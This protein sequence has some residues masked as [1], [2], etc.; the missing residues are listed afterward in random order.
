MR[1]VEFIIESTIN[2]TRAHIRD[3]LFE[4]VNDYLTTTLAK[5]N[6]K[7]PQDLFKAG[8][9]NTL[10][11]NHLALILTG[12]KIIA[13]P[14]YRAGLTKRDVGINPNDA[15][16]LFNLLNQVDKQGKDSTS[17]LNVFKSLCKMAPA[18]LKQQREALD[19]FKTG[20]DAERKHAAQDLQ[21]FVLKVAQVFNKVHV[22]AQSTRGVDIPALGAPGI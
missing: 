22:S 19:I 8:D 2:Q 7:K 13:N 20:D 3:N 14:D 1:L 21:K 18:A 6:S 12:L 15:K 17:V 9:P 11:L 4:N 10:D 16:E 5:L